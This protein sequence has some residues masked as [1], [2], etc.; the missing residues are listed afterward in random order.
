VTVSRVDIDETDKIVAL[1]FTSTN[2][3]IML[4]K[5]V[6]LNDLVFSLGG[7]SS[8]MNKI[9][10]CVEISYYEHFGVLSGCFVKSTLRSP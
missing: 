4:I 6:T 8:Q 2:N 9:D 5:V 1:Y 7:V 3:C 10:S